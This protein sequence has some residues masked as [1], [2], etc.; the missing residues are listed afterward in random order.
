MPNSSSSSGYSNNPTAN[1]VSAVEGKQATPF[2]HTVT[3]PVPPKSLASPS[4]RFPSRRLRVPPSLGPGF[5]RACSRPNSTISDHRSTLQMTDSEEKGRDGRLVNSFSVGS[6]KSTY[7]TSGSEES[8]QTRVEGS[9]ESDTS[10]IVGKSV[11]DLE[12][13]H[14][15]I[16]ERRGNIPA[17]PE[18]LVPKRS[19]GF[20]W[21]N[22]MANRYRESREQKDFINVGGERHSVKPSI[23]SSSV[24]ISQAETRARGRE[25]KKL[26]RNNTIASSLTSTTLGPPTSHPPSAFTY[27]YWNSDSTLCRA[28]SS[29]LET[30]MNMGNIMPLTP[31]RSP[32]RKLAKKRGC[33]YDAQKCGTHEDPGK[34]RREGDEESKNGNSANSGTSSAGCLRLKRSFKL[35]DGR[36]LSPQLTLAAAIAGDVCTPPLMEGEFSSGSRWEREVKGMTMGRGMGSSQLNG[37]MR[38]VTAG[39]K[40]ETYPGPEKSRERMNIKNSP[41]LNITHCPLDVSVG[42][43]FIPTPIRESIPTTTPAFATE[44]TTATAYPSESASCCSSATA[45]PLVPDR[46]PMIFR[47]SVSDQGHG[48]RSLEPFPLARIS[49]SPSSRTQPVLLR[50]TPVTPT[51]GQS[52]FSSSSSSSRL[53]AVTIESVRNAFSGIWSGKRGGK[54]GVTVPSTPSESISNGG[55]PEMS[56]FSGVAILDNDDDFTDLRDPFAS[57]RA[58]KVRRIPS[59]GVASVDLSEDGYGEPSEDL[60]ATTRSSRKGRRLPISPT[61]PLPGQSESNL[62]TSAESTTYSSRIGDVPPYSKEHRKE[63]R[64]RKRM[65]RGAIIPMARLPVLADVDFDVEEALLTQRLLKRLDDD[66]HVSG[67]RL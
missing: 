47:S 20:G 41:N 57:P 24:S 28:S 16:T 62:L 58:G 40:T 11:G 65:Q 3:P 66:V 42:T 48:Q 52:T 32:T 38:I 27:A 46:T 60:F 45:S 21:L 6:L 2:R 9:V 5:N 55:S 31:V 51:R 50:G 22:G 18:N 19:L 63:R 12:G 39:I 35:D 49:S 59:S 36:T 14:A 13:T 44:R 23:P 61:Y 33:E 25:P 17:P 37:T 64:T 43:G 53:S 30:D 29:D 1:L 34:S 67:V 56:T 26:K 54:T 10:K 15:H 8:D 7:G 4:K